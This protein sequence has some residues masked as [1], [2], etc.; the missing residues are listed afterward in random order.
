[1][2]PLKGGLCE[3]RRLRSMRRQNTERQLFVGTDAWSPTLAAVGTMGSPQYG[4]FPVESHNFSSFQKELVPQL[5]LACP[6]KEAC[7]VTLPKLTLWKRTFRK[8]VTAPAI[9]ADTSKDD[10]KEAAEGTSLSL[11][12]SSVIL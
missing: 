1:M 10:V 6:R 8:S 12:M 2:W 7:G 11:L 4:R 5:S 9:G 3:W